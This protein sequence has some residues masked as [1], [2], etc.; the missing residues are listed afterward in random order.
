MTWAD[1]ITLIKQV[2]TTDDKGFATTTDG[3]AVTVWA[4]KKSVGNKQFY[5][6]MAVGVTETMRFDVQTME[7]EGQPVIEH[8]GKRYSVLKTY[9]DPRNPDHTELSITDLQN[10]TSASVENVLDISTF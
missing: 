6:G 4:N 1:Q 7:Y 3:E 10:V 5:E 8:E 9:T 2:T